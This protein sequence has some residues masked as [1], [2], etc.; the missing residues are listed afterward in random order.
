MFWA[1]LLFG[2]LCLA[3]WLWTLAASLFPVV[4][5]I[6]LHFIYLW[7]CWVFIAA[8]ELFLIAVSPGY[9]LAWYP[10]FSLRWL[11]FLGSK[12]SRMCLV[13]LWHVESPWT[14]DETSILCIGRWILDHWT[15]R[16]VLSVVIN[17]ASTPE[18]FWVIIRLLLSG[19][20]MASR[21]YLPKF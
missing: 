11:L 13:V 3:C 6:I 14:R 19:L 12:G 17:K 4:F 8:C 15:T 16:E 18:T 20:L 9:S 7:L 1:C 21:P 2:F 10:R 5:I